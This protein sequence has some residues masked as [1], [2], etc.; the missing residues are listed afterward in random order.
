VRSAFAALG[1]H[2][3]AVG[4]ASDGGYWLVGLRRRTPP[5]FRGIP[6]GTGGVLAQTLDRAARSELAVSQLAM[7]D[8]LDTPDDLARVVAAALQR[9]DACGPNVRATLRELS[10]LPA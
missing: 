9:D 10:L 8:D 7:L 4:P 3:V 2:P 6:W 5:L 1:T